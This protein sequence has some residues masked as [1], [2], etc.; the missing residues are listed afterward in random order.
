MLQRGLGKAGL[1]LTLCHLEFVLLAGHASLQQS[2][3]YLQLRI[4]QTSLALPALKAQA[5]AG[6]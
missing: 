4:K 3:A 6:F 2:P 5:P 1:L